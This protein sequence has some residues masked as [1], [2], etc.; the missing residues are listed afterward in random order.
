MYLRI[1]LLSDAAFG[2]GDGVAGVVDSE[3]EH[4]SKTGLPFIKGRTIKGLM[5]EAC[6]DII[7]GLSRC[8]PKAHNSFYDVASDLFGIPGSDINS[9]GILHFHAATLPSDFV[10]KIKQ[11][12]YKSHKI[13]EALTDIRRQTAVDSKSDTPLDHSLRNIRVIIRKTVFHAPVTTDYPLDD[14][15]LALLA[16][17]ANTVHHAGQNRTRGLGYIKVTLEKLIKYDHKTCVTGF[18]QLVKEAVG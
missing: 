9:S 1:E 18:E 6:A 5:V 13:L 10:S 15:S 11:S 16:A 12:E 7:F 8:C 2:R 17:C 4:D 14:K 3:V